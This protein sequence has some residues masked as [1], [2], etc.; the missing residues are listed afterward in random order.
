M[1]SIVA[2]L[3][4]ALAGIFIG[5]FWYSQSLLGKPWRLLSRVTRKTVEEAS[6]W[7]SYL[8]SFV[9][10]FV[11]SF[12]LAVFI[13]YANVASAWEGLLIGLL[14]WAGFV[15]AT[16]LNPV[17]WE[18]QPFKLYLINAGHYFVSFLVMSLI[19]AAW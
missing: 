4:A 15:A 18:R 14:A 1:I 11:M 16:M 12:V 10:T 7:Q 17:L 8:V 6:S 3:V 5:A 13:E 2:I 9:A 19:L